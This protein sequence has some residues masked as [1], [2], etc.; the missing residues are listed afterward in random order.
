MTGASKTAAMFPADIP[1]LRVLSEPYAAAAAAG[2]VVGAMRTPSHAQLGDRL[3]ASCRAHGLPLALYEVPCVHQ[4]IDPRG[5]AELPYTKANFVRFLLERHQ[6]P[7]LYLDADCVFAERPALVDELLATRTDFAIFNWLAEEHTEAYVR[8]QI[9]LE[10]GLEP[11]TRFDQL[12]RFSH[13]IDWLCPT[14]LL[15]SGAVQ[16]YANSAAAKE[17]LS[18]WQGVIER[19]PRRADDKCLDFAFNHYPASSPTLTAAWLGKAYARYAWWIYERPVIDHPEF[20]SLGEGFE[21]FVTLDGKPRID[22]IKLLPQRVS[23]AFPKEC[24]LDTHSRLMYRLEAGTWRVVGTIDTPLWL[25][26]VA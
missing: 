24:L 15:A 21:P 1:G 19:S 6:C 12:Y 18:L 7:V 10:Q 17:L 14:Q 8:A 13:S 20:P 16:W 22:P 23:Y 3:T 5:S 2:Y 4:S 11:G 9:A 26:P 25:S